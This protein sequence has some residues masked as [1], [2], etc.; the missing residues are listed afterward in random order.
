VPVDVHVPGCPP[1]PE[2]VVD[3]LLLIQKKIRA[4]IA[5]AYDLEKSK[6]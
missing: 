1:R 5:P 4:G 3:G 2:A 6:A